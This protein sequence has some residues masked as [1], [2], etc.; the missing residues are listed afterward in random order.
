MSDP[1]IVLRLKEGNER[2]VSSGVTNVDASPSLRLL[3]AE[4]GQHPCA[5][6]ITCSDSRVIPEVIFSAGIGELFVIRVAG[7]VLGEHALGSVEYAAA[8]LGCRLAVVLGH[9]QCGAV[10]AAL[11][12][13][14]EGFIRS[15]TDEIKLAIGDERDYDTACRLNV[16]RAVDVLR[17]T[18][19]GHPEISPEGLEVRG[20]LYDIASG[21][22]EWL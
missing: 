15:I 17:K 7:N 5:V 11:S 21:A 18:F 6:V 22:V 12:G 1:S 13:Q 9:T 3:T 19:A 10:G 4:H 16:G 20:A 14:S 8:H 2:Y